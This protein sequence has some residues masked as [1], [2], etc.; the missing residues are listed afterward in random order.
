MSQ[1]KTH[2]LHQRIERALVAPDDK[3][4]RETLAE[5]RAADIAEAFELFDDQ[6]R[7]RMI[8]AMPARTAAEVVIMLPE[9]VRGDVVDD[10]DD[11]II[12]G[13]VAELPPD[14]AAD[15]VA[16]LSDAQ[17]AEVLGH[18][19]PEQSVKIGELLEYDKDSAG[20]IMTPE[21]VAVTADSTVRDTVRHIR[22]ASSDEDLNEI[23]IV[24]DAKTLVGVVPLRKLVIY[25]REVSL[26][27]LFEPDPISV[28]VDDDQEEV[29]HAMRKYDLAQVPV[30]DAGGR[31]VGRI[32]HDDILDVA[33]EE[34]AEDLYRMAGTDPAE[35]ESSSPFRAASIRLVW[36]LPCMGVTLLTGAAMAMIKP[37]FDLK[38][39]GVLILFVPMIAAM[40]GNCGIQ[41]STVIIRGFAEGDRAGRRLSRVLRRE[42]PIVLIL[43][44]ICACAAFGLVWFFL[45]LMDKSFAPAVTAVSVPDSTIRPSEAGTV[46]DRV[47]SHRIDRQKIAK[48]VCL[49]MLSAVLV[50]AMLGIALPFSFRAV[51]VDPA[52]ASGPLVTALNDVTSVTAYLLIATWLAM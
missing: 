16:E 14:D 45:P 24:D 34:A 48:S 30:V 50:A 33:E 37:Q 23:Y 32:T 31:L 4:L 26:R 3:L 9:A 35:R 28:H 43:A 36:L 39:F 25:D 20:G 7:S 38:V 15:I 49:G 13:I 22:D 40:G 41:I 8:Y 2:D 51:S 47:G 17:S 5:D 44:P 1:R 10:L 21:F 27:Q 19:E 52:I 11:Q 29:V 6:E 18:I 12:T 42:V 46:A